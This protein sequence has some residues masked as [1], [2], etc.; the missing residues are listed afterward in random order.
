MANKKQHLPFDKRGGRIVMC[1]HLIES[2]NYQ[3]LSTHARCLMVLLQVQWRNDKAVDY[4]VREAE[5]RLG[6][7]RK[8][9]MKAFNL[10]M[11]RGFIIC[12]EQSLFSTRTQSKSRSWQ[13]TWLPFNFNDPVNTWENWS[14]IN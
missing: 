9:V 11:E 5:V 4:G 13:L 1:R 6:C 2:K 14:E 12:T 10:L 7:N 8:T 3:T